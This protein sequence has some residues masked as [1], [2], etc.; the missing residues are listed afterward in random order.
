[1]HPPLSV[2]LVGDRSPWDLGILHKN[3]EPPFA[4]GLVGQSLLVLNEI[5]GVEKTRMREAEASVMV[6]AFG[7]VV[8]SLDVLRF[9]SND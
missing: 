8:S 5:D 7:C 2:D 3:A 9:T 4:R 1:M 6:L